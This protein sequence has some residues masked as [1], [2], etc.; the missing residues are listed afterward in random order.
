MNT[1]T[2]AD[3]IANNSV[4]EFTKSVPLKP[5]EAYILNQIIFKVAGEVL[6][7]SEKLEEIT[8]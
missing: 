8:A 1:E 4:I 6:S 7:A 3:Q 5:E 2:L